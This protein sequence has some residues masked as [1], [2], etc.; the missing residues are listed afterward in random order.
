VLSNA[1]ISDSSTDR[2]RFGPFTLDVLARALTR[3]AERLALEPRAF[4]TLA[5]LVKHHQRVVGKDE[6]ISAVWGRVD[7]S[8]Q[9]VIQA[10]ARVR[11]ALAEHAEW[12]ETRPRV[13]YRFTASLAPWQADPEPPAA[14]PRAARARRWPWFVAALL[15]AAVWIS[16]W[17][18]P[19][20]APLA[21]SR[22]IELAPFRGSAEAPRGLAALLKESIQHYAPRGVELHVP[23][24]EAAP[25]PRAFARL[26][27]R[28]EATVTGWQID[29][30]LHRGR[31]STPLPRVVEATV[32]GVLQR[33]AGRVATQLDPGV[34]RPD[35][36]A[37]LSHVQTRA[38]ALEARWQGDV[39]T[40][41]AL[42]LRIPE[43]ERQQPEIALEWAAVACAPDGARASCDA[44]LAE[45]N[46]RALPP[47]LKVR[48]ALL[49]GRVQRER[50]RLDDADAALREAQTLLGAEGDGL[51]RA[52]VLHTLGMVAFDRGA[53]DQARAH[54]AAAATVLLGLGERARYAAL[55]NN[56]GAIAAM[57][58]DYEEALTTFEQ[59]RAA[60]A[61]F[62]MR[63]D[64]ALALANLAEVQ[65]VLGRKTLA[66]RT[67]ERAVALDPPALAAPRAQLALARAAL[68]VGDSARATAALAQ[69]EALAPESL[70]A[71]GPTR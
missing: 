53:F 15:G 49:R 22:S 28:L 59:A 50:G 56:N 40:A 1:P 61:E 67:A 37:R 52:S 62:N 20:P 3:G 58:G 30:E 17:Q 65:G 47:A 18:W 25:N 42:L 13:G 9:S 16:A 34:V 21:A 68:D 4:D 46:R 12:I 54:N 6:L 23:S 66:L 55:A 10:V 11:R 69:A 39:A 14:P 2:V 48:E 36:P 5:Y 64:E 26:E 51:L 24:A 57:Q 19:S 71:R 70:R 45:L 63:G 27:T 32:E 43:R 33:Y 35:A 60:F 8:D 31:Q 44:L 29:G 41:R 38:L 7:A